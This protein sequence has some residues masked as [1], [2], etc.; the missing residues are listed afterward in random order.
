VK[1]QE[2]FSLKSHNTFGIE[3]KARYFAHVS[4]EEELKWVLEQKE[5]PQ[6]LILGGGSNMLLTGDVD[7]LVIHI[8]LM[9]I[10]V[11][12]QQ[13]KYTY[14]Q[15]MAG[16]NWHELVL[17]T[18]EKDLGG[19]EN[20]S[21]IPG[22]AGS[23]PIQNIGAYGVELKDHF[24]GCEAIEIDTGIKRFFSKEDCRFGYRES[25]FKN[26]AKGKF[27][28][29]SV[30]LRLTSK[31]HMLRTEYGTIG[32]ELGQ[33]G[34]LHPTIQDISRAVIRIRQRKL[35]DPAVLGNSGSFFKNPV[36]ERAKLETLRGK[37][38]N[39]PFYEISKNEFKIPAAWLIDRCG[40]KGMR[41][42]DAGVHQH[43]ALVLVNHGHASG[44]EILNLAR[45]IQ[46][47]VLN[48]FDI[49]IHPEVNII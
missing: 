25:I 23:A 29:T 37:Y 48:A 43:Q 31:D 3:A 39:I 36:V 34:V 33:S 35:P 18:L 16:E 1:I 15:V 38:E 44:E 7:A 45:R 8:G 22:S 42:G 26:E 32:E 14:I 10:E 17:W 2:G 20:L 6:R 47:E 11:V 5:Y 30:T 9:G 19:L 21:L 49:A 13:G 4:T 12:E 41:V 28:I 40:F 46:V 24:E 27:V